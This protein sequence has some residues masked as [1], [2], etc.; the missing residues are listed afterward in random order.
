M[1]ANKTLLLLGMLCAAP[2]LA[3]TDDSRT[4]RVVLGSPDQIP[5]AAQITAL[6]AEGATLR[7]IVADRREPRYL[8][9]RAASLLG[10]FD[11][12]EV[13]GQLARVIDASDD[14]IEVRVQA[15]DALAR[16]EGGTA[17]LS[18]ALASPD[19]AMR[20]VAVIGL[21][22]LRAHAILDRHRLIERDPAILSRIGA[23]RRP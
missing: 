14:D 8:R 18:R 13:R 20:E 21:V 17:R 1:R 3:E 23:A 6:D 19:K 5:T 2:A 4:L 16:M 11:R 10:L 12:P 22:R 9:M 15:L 7:A